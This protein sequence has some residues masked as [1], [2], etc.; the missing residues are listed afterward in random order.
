MKLCPITAQNGSPAAQQL[1]G[2]LGTVESLRSAWRREGHF[3]LEQLEREVLAG[4]QSI[5]RSIVQAELDRIAATET[6]EVECR[7]EKLHRVL[8]TCKTYL[9]RFGEVDVEPRGIAV[10]AVTGPRCARWR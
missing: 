8:V 7:G 5:G 1:A 4:L 3:D 6:A 9:T 10:V 2:L